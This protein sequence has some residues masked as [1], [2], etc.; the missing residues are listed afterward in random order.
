MSEE[1]QEAYKAQT[2][3]APSNVEEYTGGKK[4]SMFD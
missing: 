4:R 3:V 2:I 1:D